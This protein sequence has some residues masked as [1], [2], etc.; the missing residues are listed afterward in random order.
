MIIQS[1]SYRMQS[2]REF[3]SKHAIGQSVTSGLPA[4]YADSGIVPFPRK[5]RGDA[6][7][8]GLSGGGFYQRSPIRNTAHLPMTPQA[9]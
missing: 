9:A 1:G 3:T 4:G 2:E 7:E 6:F 8:G 5:E